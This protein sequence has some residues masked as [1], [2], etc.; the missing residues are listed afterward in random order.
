MA[1]HL[2]RL[3]ERGEIVHHINGVKN[4]NQIE[5]LK[6]TSVHNHDCS[7]RMGYERGTQD[8]EEHSRKEM[9][10]LRWQVM[11]LTN[12]VKELKQALFGV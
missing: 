11:E 6:L 5:N 9:R 10:L 12:S 2:G 8:A 4:D 7:Y 1:E 3:L